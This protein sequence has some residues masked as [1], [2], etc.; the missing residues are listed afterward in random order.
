MITVICL[1]CFKFLVPTLQF[2]SRLINNAQ[3]SFQFQ[4]QSDDGV[5]W[6]DVAGCPKSRKMGNQIV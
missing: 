3:Y 1:S 6:Q 5:E 4:L 2:L